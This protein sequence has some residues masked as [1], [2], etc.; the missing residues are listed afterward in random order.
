MGTLSWRTLADNVVVIRDGTM[1]EVSIA[2]DKLARM[3]SCLT[4]CTPVQHKTK[5]LLSI[6]RKRDLFEKATLFVDSRVSV[7]RAARIAFQVTM[8]TEIGLE[9]PFLLL[10]GR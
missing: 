9:A 6:L 4:E 3:W 10:A 1:A 7:H 5:S 2:I 8:R